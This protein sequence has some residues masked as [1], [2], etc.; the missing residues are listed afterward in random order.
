MKKEDAIK[1]VR[2]Y[3]NYRNRDYTKL[4]LD[5]VRLSEKEEIVYGKYENQVRKVF[6]VPYENEGYDHPIT[7]FVFVD[8]ET[9]E[10]LYTMSPSGYVEEW[11]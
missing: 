2:S 7:F 10:V 8:I 1:I 9:E 3:L 6:C 11:E 4:N 5:S